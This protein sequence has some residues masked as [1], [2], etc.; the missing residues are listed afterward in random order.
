MRIFA[1]KKLLQINY[2]NDMIDLTGIVK[3]VTKSSN[4]MNHNG[5]VNTNTFKAFC[6]TIQVT[7]KNN[8]DPYLNVCLM[9]A[10]ESLNSGPTLANK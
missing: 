9:H 6:K 4:S 8:P 1:S 3:Q 7:R 10:V 5:K 2:K